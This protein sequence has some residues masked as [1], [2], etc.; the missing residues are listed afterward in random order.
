MLAQ[1]VKKQGQINRADAW[2]RALRPNNIGEIPSGMEQYAHAIDKRPIILR[3]AGTPL[4]F[5]LAVHNIP[6]YK[7]NTDLKNILKKRFE[8]ITGRTI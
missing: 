8:A 5:D 7:Y 3:K 2:G 1:I 4:H 6:E